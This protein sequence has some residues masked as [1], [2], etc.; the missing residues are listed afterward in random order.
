MFLWLTNRFRQAVKKRL[1]KADKNP[2]QAL[3]WKTRNTVCHTNDRDPQ[4]RKIRELLGTFPQPK[5]L[6]ARLP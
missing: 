4:N 3:G 6:I 1:E 2:P 5:E